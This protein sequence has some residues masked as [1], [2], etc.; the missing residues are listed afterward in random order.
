M[1]RIDDQIVAALRDGDGWRSTRAVLDDVQL[2]VR[3]TYANLWI[4]LR[5]LEGEGRVERRG[6]RGA[7]EWRRAV[8]S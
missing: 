1:S 2:R 3:V 5:R 7:F 4:H 6:A 8:V